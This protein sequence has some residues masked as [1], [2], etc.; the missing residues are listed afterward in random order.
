M[1]NFV[2]FQLKHPA[3]SK[4]IFPSLSFLSLPPDLVK[5]RQVCSQWLIVYV[6]VSEV[7]GAP[8]F[9]RFPILLSGASLLMSEQ[10]QWGSRY[11]MWLH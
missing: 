11:L 3:E 7:A 8:T 5:G 6:C 2:P 4:T 9:T 10:E 1:F